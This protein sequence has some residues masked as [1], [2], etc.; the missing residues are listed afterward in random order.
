MAVNKNYK[1]N[2]KEFAE[3]IKEGGIGVLPTDTVFGLVGSA[4]SKKAVERIY[5]IKER[6]PQSPFIVLIGSTQDLEKFNIKL[7]QE[8][9]NF[10]QKNWPGK[11]SV[12]L[13]CSSPKFAYL[14]QGL[15]SLAFR[16]P[17]K[18]ALVDL[19]KKT[20]PLVAPS[21]NPKG[22]KLAKNITEAKKYFGNKIDFYVSGKTNELPSTLVKIE[23]GKLVILREGAKKIK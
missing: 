15:K 21:A 18:K 23:K 12:I 8:S 5:E 7:N 16:W 1:I 4:F 19:I 10:L 14:H 13:P 17:R 11:I 2:Q 6:N 9:K 22:Q 3:L 20:G